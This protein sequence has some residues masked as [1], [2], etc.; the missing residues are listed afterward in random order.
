MKKMMNEWRKFVNETKPK[1]PPKSNPANPYDR[2]KTS[3]VQRKTEGPMELIRYSLAQ[4]MLPVSSYDVG[5]APNFEAIIHEI[6]QLEKS[7]KDQV[8]DDLK[9]LMYIYNRPMG[10]MLQVGDKSIDTEFFANIFNDRQSVG[11][12]GKLKS[13][14]NEFGIVSFPAGQGP[15]PDQVEKVF[16][17]Y[18]MPKNFDSRFNKE[19]PTSNRFATQ[20]KFSFD[21]LMQMNQDLRNRNK[22]KK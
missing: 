5:Q 6:S 16:K 18:V 15:S 7:M 20:Q 3:F 21:Q 19:E 22:R 2:A 4:Y 8:F 9:V 10:N 12:V 11:I 1:H 13:V 17:F 14:M